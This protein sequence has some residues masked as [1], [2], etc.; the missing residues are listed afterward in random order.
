MNIA[1]VNELAVFARDLDIDVWD[2]IDAASTKPFGYMRFTP[3]PGVGGHCLPIDPSYLSWSVRQSL[4]RTFR[5]VELANDVNDHMP[6]YVV[7]RLS[8]AFN[9]QG[10]AVSGRRILLLGLAY[11]RNTGDARESP[12]QSIADQLAALGADV[13][14]ADPHVD[15]RHTPTGVTRVEATVEEAAAADAVIVVVDHDD[16]DLPTLVTAARYVFDTKHCVEGP[17]VEH[18]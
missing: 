8:E 16:F 17:N 3:G 9:A 5:F 12:S 7:R 11:K 6:D 1:L 10:L 14:A 15:D 13:R 2:A 4:G 18:L